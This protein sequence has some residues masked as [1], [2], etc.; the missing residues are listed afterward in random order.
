MRIFG[1]EPALLLG[2]ISAALSLVV[3]LGIGLTSVQAGTITAAITATFAAITAAMTRPIAPAA[4]TG[5]V[6][7]A[8]DLLAA[9]HYEV[10]A[11]TIGAVNALV[12]AVLMFVTRGQ[13]S[14]VPPKPPVP[15]PAAG[16]P[17][18]EDVTQGAP[19]KGAVAVSEEWAA[20][21]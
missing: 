5:A 8:A 6:T 17:A 11:E 7:A 2:V 1:R 19:V 15:A 14:P 20:E 10:S 13:V 4:F 21:G 18:R 16:E 12:L 9:F 3:T